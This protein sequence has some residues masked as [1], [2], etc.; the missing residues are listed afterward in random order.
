MPDTATPTIVATTTGAMGGIVAFM[1]AGPAVSPAVFLL[2][3]AAGGVAGG[4]FS[5]IADSQPLTARSL[6]GVAGL[7]A[8]LGPVLVFAAMYGL[9]LEATL[10]ALGLTSGLVGA[11][12]WHIIKRL[13]ELMRWGITAGKA[14]L[15]AMLPKGPNN[16]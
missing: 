16:G 4:L 6:I 3:S 13:P 2:A 10:Q 9:G 5:S 14:A 8:M 12:S 15:I 1:S 7:G 11:C